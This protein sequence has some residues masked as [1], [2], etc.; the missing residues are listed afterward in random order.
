MGNAFQRNKICI[1]I[2]FIAACIKYQWLDKN[3]GVI[4]HHDECPKFVKLF[5]MMKEIF[6]DN[7]GDI[8]LR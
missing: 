2:F 6:D 8:I 3:M 4:R 5:S 7:S 1:V